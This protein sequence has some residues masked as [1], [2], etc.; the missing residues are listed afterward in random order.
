M[1]SILKFENIRKFHKVKILFFTIIEVFISIYDRCLILN[2][3]YMVKF[4]NIEYS[5]IDIAAAA[6]YTLLGFTTGLNDNLCLITTHN[7][8]Y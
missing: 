5:N 4:E 7:K 2:K 3:C 8:S 6:V 1:A